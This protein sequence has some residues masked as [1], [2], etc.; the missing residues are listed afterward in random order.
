MMPE[1][2]ETTLVSAAK[3]AE[4]GYVSI[5]GNEEVNVY[6]ANNTE[7]KVSRSAVLRGY[8]CPQTGL[9]RIPLTRNPITE[10]TNVNTDTVIV[11]KCP[12][13][14]LPERPSPIEAI[15]NVLEL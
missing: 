13:E 3:L 15:F 4:S 7:I 9:W 8:K 12:T 1:L 10:K 5:F 2:T 6:D 14:Y 11:D